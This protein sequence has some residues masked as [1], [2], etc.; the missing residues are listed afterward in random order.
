M[1]LTACQSTKEAANLV[2]LDVKFDWNNTSACS[3]ISPAF[4]ITNVP[5]E[6][7]ILK[8]TMTDLNV[9]T[10][11]HGGGTVTYMGEANI[12]AGSFTYTGPCPPSGTHKYRF[13]VVAL[14]EDASLVLGKGE[15]TQEFP[16]KN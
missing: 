15:F 12:P 3:S 8:F 13:R 9:P 7:K 5:A 14:N 4:D 6:T 1:L 11:H 2:N 10:F 16:P